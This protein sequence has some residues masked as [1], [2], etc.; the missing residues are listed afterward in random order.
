[1]IKKI[2]PVLVLLAVCSASLFSCKKTST[3]T[4]DVTRNYFPLVFGKYVTYAVDSVIW[5]GKA[6]TRY[7]VKSQMKY[8][9]TDTYTVNRQLSYIMSVYWRPY[10]GADWVGNSV[11]LLTPTT[12]SLLYAQSQVQFIKLMFPI[13]NGLTWQ[14]NANA[15]VLDSTLSYLAGWNYTYQNYHLSYFNGL[16]NFDNTVTLMEDDQNVNYQN[17][18]SAVAGYRTYAKEVYAYNVGMIYKEW[19]HYTFGPPDTAQNKEGSSVIMQ[20]IDYN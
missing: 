17:V 2:L 13:S 18:D 12:S 4:V 20:A 19:T 11:I 3:S 5:Y 7:E 14:G 15:A 9:V 16:V 8:E 10:D 1:M 6:G